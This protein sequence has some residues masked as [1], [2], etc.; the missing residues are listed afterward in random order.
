MVALEFL[1]QDA[2][3]SR[4]T[5]VDASN[6]SNELRRLS[7]MWTVRHHW[8]AR[9]RFDFNFYSHWAQPLL[10]H[11]GE[12]PVTIQSQEGVNQ[13]DPQSM[14]LYRINLVPLSKKLRAAYSWLL[15]PLYADDAALDSL[16]RQSAQL[17]KLLIKR[18]MD[19]GYFPEPA[20]SLFI[21]NTPWQEEVVKREFAAEGLELNFV[22]GSRY[23]GAYLGHQ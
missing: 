5:L 15:S 12:T 4:T 9:M 19:R 6:G 11:L 22:S 10:R 13:G 16:S 17:L 3:P 8:P 7:M 18:G 23:L 2:E 14:V 1:T 21:P 20:K